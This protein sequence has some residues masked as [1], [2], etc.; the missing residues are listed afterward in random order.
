MIHLDTH[1]VVWLAAGETGRIPA[2]LRGRLEAEPMVVSPMARLELD[3][4][5]EL[6]RITERGAPILEGLVD[7]I[8]LDVASEPLLSVI[9]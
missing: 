1:V 8:G 5:H 6:G 3:Y 7:R 4:L 9:R 2:T